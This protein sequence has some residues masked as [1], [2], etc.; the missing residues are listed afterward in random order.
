MREVYIRARDQAR[1]AEQLNRL[2]VLVKM[3]MEQEA[4]HTTLT[5]EKILQR[6]ETEK[7][8]QAVITYAALTRHAYNAV[9]AAMGVGSFNESETSFKVV[10]MVLNGLE[11]PYKN[12]HFKEIE[13]EAAELKKRGSYKPPEAHEPKPPKPKDVN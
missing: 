1:R 9:A 2:A 3:Q 13:K 10:D 5:H 6:K 11:Q 7:W 4:K 8:C 12:A